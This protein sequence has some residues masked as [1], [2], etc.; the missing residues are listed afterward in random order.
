[1][2]VQPTEALIAVV[3]GMKFLLPVLYLRWPFAAGWGNL[4]LDS[5]DGDILVPA[6][7]PEPT[8]QIVDKVADYWAYVFMLLWGWNQPIRREVALTFSLRT[9]GQMLFFATRNELAL[10]YFPN[11]LEPLFLVYATMIRL[12]GSERAH[13]IYRRHIVLIWAGIMLYKLQ[14]EWI[15][16]VANVDRTTLLKQLLDR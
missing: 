14:D 10:F 8:Y 11:L 13:D 9:V 5:I 6:G 4:V 2:S 16:H 3:I 1:M 12:A 15:T 7:L